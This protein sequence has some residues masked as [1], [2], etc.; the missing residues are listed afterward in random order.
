MRI[1][2]RGALENFA[3]RAARSGSRDERRIDTGHGHHL[4]AQF[5]GQPAKVHQPRDRCDQSVL[6]PH[7]TSMAYFSSFFPVAADGES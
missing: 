7:N 4:A 3:Q 6:R 2:I 5:I 1:F